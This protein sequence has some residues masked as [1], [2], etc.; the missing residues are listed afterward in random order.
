MSK[1]LKEPLCK[2]CGNEFTKL[3][4]NDLY[5]GFCMEHLINKCRS[6]FK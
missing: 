5:C 2:R 3:E 6:K 4:P 1:T